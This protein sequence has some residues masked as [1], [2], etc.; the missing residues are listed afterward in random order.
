MKRSKYQVN[1]TFERLN[2]NFISEDMTRFALCL[3][4]GKVY[5]S[6]AVGFLQALICS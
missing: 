5:L 2:S 1:E 4:V 6:D 3:Y